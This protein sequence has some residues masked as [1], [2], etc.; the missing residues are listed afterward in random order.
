MVAWEQKRTRDVLILLNGVMLAIVLSQIASLFYFRLDLTE[1]KRYTIKEPTIALLQNLEDDVYVDVFLEGDLNAEF[2]RLRKAIRETLEEFRVYSGNK[3]HYRFSDPMAATGANA[4]REFMSDLVSKGIKPIN[5]IDSKDGRRT[6]KIVFPG[7]LISFGG[8]QT[9]V[10]LLKDQVGQGAQEDL[11]R[12]IEGLEFEFAN[13]VHL[14]TVTA[15]KQIGFVS[16]HGVLD[17]LQVASLREGLSALYDVNLRAR[18]N[19]RISLADFD[20]LIIAKPQRKFS[21]QEKY[22]LDQYVMGGG[23]VIFLIDALRADMDSV[24][25]GDYYSFPYQ[26][27]LEDMLFQY[28]LRINEGFVQ[29]LVSLRYP[30]VTGVQNGKP[31]ITPIEWPY[32][33]LANHYAAHPATRNLDATAFRFANSLDTVKATGIRKTPLLF[34]SQYSRRVTAPLKINVNDLR[35]EIKPENFS[36]G[37]QPMAY[38]LEG[39]FTSL[40]KN[41]FLPEGVDSTANKI[42]GDFS[43]LMVVAD[44]DL[45]RNEIN[46]RTGQALELGFDAVSNHTFANRELLLNM[47]AFMTDESGLITARNREIL[48]RPL[49]KEKIRNSRT[50]WQIIN[51]GLPFVLLLILGLTKAYFRHRRYG[52]FATTLNDGKKPA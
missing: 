20:A 44:G 23:K 42:A 38:L 11:N 14:L 1:E 48:V 25:L 13:A 16:G 51:L 33:P 2:R 41:R 32:F 43:Q 28:G 15:R 40:Y 30:I 35:K 52:K 36:A 37:P 50:A 3:L 5:I 34:S 21:E 19:T 27:G 10:M 17:S 46:R 18:L 45:A 49:D 9:G 6:E 24:S 22:V 7:A 12:A 4:Q 8:Q 26:L 39:S 31:Q 29:D 47:I